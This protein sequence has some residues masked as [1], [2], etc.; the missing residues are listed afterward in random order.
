M[1]LPSHSSKPERVSALPENPAQHVSCYFVCFKI[2]TRR[3][4]NVQSSTFRLLGNVTTQAKAWTLNIVSPEDAYAMR[5]SL[6]SG[7]VP[8]GFGRWETIPCNTFRYRLAHFTV[9]WPFWLCQLKGEIFQSD[10]PIRLVSLA[11]TSINCL[12]PGGLGI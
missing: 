1:G 7:L 3:R 6:V 11:T 12:G 9:C 8:R 10:S 5:G 4:D 2:K